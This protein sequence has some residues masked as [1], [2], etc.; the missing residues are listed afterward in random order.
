MSLSRLSVVEAIKLVVSS[1]PTRRR[2]PFV[3]DFL[4][5]LLE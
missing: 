2:R 4:K 3:P 1:L 5:D